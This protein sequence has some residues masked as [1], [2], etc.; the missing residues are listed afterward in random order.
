MIRYNTYLPEGMIGKLK[1]AAR[2]AE[3]SVAEL[4]RSIIREWLARGGK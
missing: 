2:K 4:I 1:A 3:M